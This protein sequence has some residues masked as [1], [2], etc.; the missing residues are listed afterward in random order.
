M[1]FTI[2]LLIALSGLLATTNIAMQGVKIGDEAKVL[3]SIPLKVVAKEKT[4]VKYRTE[5]GNF[6]SISTLNGKVVY[7]EN[8]WLQDFKATKPLFTDF[9]FGKTSL[10]DIRSKYG[11]NGFVHNHQ[12]MMKTATDIVQFNC[13]E[14]DSPNNEVL[15][16]ITKTSLKADVNASN[17]ADH[18]KL[19][20]LIIADKDY[21]ESIW[22]KSKTFDQNYKKIK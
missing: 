2:V 15:V 8:D 12:G 7:M 20:A 18:A 17:I 1:N 11:T 22:G 6:L 16:T 9:E 21:L 13:F 10:N 5:N 19:D 4:M 3:K 14:F